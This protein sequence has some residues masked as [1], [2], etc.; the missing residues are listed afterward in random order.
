LHK[1]SQQASLKT[2]S[3]HTACVNNNSNS[4]SDECYK[5]NLMQ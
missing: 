1:T 2:L 3:A 5:R 4:P